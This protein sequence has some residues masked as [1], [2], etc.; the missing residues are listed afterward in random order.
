MKSL[1]I[2]ADDDTPKVY[3]D[4]DAGIFL[5]EGKSLPENAFDF[6]EP[7]LKWVEA[8]FNSE[9]TTQKTAVNFNLDYFNTASSKQIAKLLKIIENS[10]ASE[11]VTVKWHYDEEDTDMLKAGKR[12]GK[13][14]KIHFEFIE[15]PEED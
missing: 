11:T 6:Y 2:E 15:N 5:L 9:N 10:P 8:F 3:L 14:I 1:H 13:L 4:P 12:Y 7:I